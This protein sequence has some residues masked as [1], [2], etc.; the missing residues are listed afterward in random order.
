MFSKLGCSVLGYNLNH[1]NNFGID[2]VCIASRKKRVSQIT[3][4]SGF[5]Y[6]SSNFGCWFGFK[7]SVV[8]TKDIT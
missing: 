6:R 1:A 5:D 2:L 4:I 3:K 7:V 8:K